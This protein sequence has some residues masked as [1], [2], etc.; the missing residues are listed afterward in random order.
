MKASSW[1]VPGALVLFVLW[2]AKVV[3]NPAGAIP[4]EAQEARPGEVWRFV[5]YDLN[6][7]RRETAGVVVLLS[8]E[9]LGG[10]EWQKVRII[11]PMPFAQGDAAGNIRSAV[12]LSA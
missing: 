6:R 4:R 9:N 1:I 3:S 11:H 2:G 12:R 7:F 5:A 10:Q 8:V